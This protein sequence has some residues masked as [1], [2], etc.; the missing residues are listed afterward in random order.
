MCVALALT[1]PSL[2]A[3]DTVIVRLPL[4]LYEF[5]FDTLRGY[6]MIRSNDNLTINLIARR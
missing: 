3:Q 6:D 2:K 4:S 5:R 1:V